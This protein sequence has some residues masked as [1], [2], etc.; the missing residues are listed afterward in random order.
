MQLIPPTLAKLANSKK[1]VNF[2]VILGMF[3]MRDQ[4]GLTLDW[5]M[6][7]VIGFCAVSIAQGFAD[8]GKGATVVEGFG[9]LPN[10]TVEALAMLT[11]ANET[12]TT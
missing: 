1:N 5:F 9:D 4:I 11:K 7:I 2:Y 6:W 3:F 12:A 10:A 8:W